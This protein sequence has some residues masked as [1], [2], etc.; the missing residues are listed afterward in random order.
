MTEGTVKN[1]RIYSL[2]IIRIV[3]TFCILVYHYEQVFAFKAGGILDFVDLMNG[4]LIVELFFV[5]S[6][7]LAFFDINRIKTGEYS[8]TCYFTKKYKRLITVIVAPCLAY[9]LLCYLI[10]RF[11]GNGGWL[12]DTVVDIPATL[13]AMLGVQF[14]GNIS[15]IHYINFPL[16]YVDILLLCYIV[17]AV[18]IKLATR[19]KINPIY[20][21]IVTCLIGI[22]LWDRQFDAPF[23][24]AFIARGLYAFFAGVLL[25]Y[26]YD[27]M[28]KER[29]KS[30]GLLLAYALIFIITT[31]L[32]MF[33]KE[34]LGSGARYI[35]TFITYPALML[36]FLH[37]V[38]QKAFNLKWLGS[39]GKVTYDIYAWHL[40]V[41]LALV[42][43]DRVGVLT[44]NFDSYGILT[45]A[46][47]SAIV[48]GVLS[49][50]FVDRFVM[51]II[52]KC[53]KFFEQ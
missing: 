22:A 1:N 18:I 5:L 9:T 53:H 50:F 17:M 47:A 3:A 37:P 52:G 21:F 33:Y 13:S 29:A 34:W 45:L 26:I 44:L 23:I 10:R 30:V 25:A 16:W 8:F 35:L 32:F 51:W 40:V 24:N 12:F 27:A 39:V 14:W 31:L 6:G 48:M 11:T 7:F 49:Y 43:K 2:D 46:I 38:M 15:T 28:N 42:F 41:Y 36:F 19:V 4:S 20:G